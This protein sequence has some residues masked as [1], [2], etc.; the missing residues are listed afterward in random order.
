MRTKK[1]LIVLGYTTVTAALCFALIE[2]CLGDVQWNATCLGLNW[3]DQGCGNPPECQMPDGGT[4]CVHEVMPNGTTFGL[5][6]SGW[7]G[8][9]HLDA[10]SGLTSSK[11]G[12]SCSVD[13]VTGMD[14]CTS[15]ND[16]CACTPMTGTPWHWDSCTT[17]LC[18]NDTAYP[19]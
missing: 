6:C 19:G 4:I 18:F 17:T 3:Y 13:R 9:C 7:E 10:F 5:C 11:Y 8:G 2:R 12:L 14:S 16:Y 1:S 15:P